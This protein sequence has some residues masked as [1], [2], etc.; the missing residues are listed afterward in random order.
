MTQPQ[1]L[2]AVTRPSVRAIRTF[3]ISNTGHLSPVTRRPPWNAGVNTAQCHPVRLLGGPTGRR[4]DEHQAP[5]PG[6]HCGFWGL[7]SLQ[8]LRESGY[9]AQSRVLAVISCHGTLIPAELGVRAQHARIEALWLSPRV[10]DHTRERVARAYPDA[11]MY[12]SLDAMLREH[13][14]TALPSYRLPRAPSRARLLAPLVATFTWWIA[15]LCALAAAH[16]QHPQPLTLGPGPNALTDAPLVV[17]MAAAGASVLWPRAWQPIAASL[18]IQTLVPA[19]C[20]AVADPWVSYLQ[21][22]TAAAAGG[23][24]VAVSTVLAWRQLHPE[25]RPRRRRSTRR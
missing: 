9:D 19:V 15:V 1:P 12:A 13:D 22:V 17:A 18:T 21:L 8:A 14:L 20:A 3:K 2:D 4:G 23:L 11:A 10:D 25:P 16:A 5:A 24:Q 7:G 6:C